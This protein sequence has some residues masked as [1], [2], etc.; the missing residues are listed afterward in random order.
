[1]SLADL[2]AFFCLSSAKLNG[3]ISTIP[4]KQVSDCLYVIRVKIVK[5][6]SWSKFFVRNYMVS[7]SVMC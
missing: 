1:M 6:H 3:E 5:I 2:S 4:F 7:C